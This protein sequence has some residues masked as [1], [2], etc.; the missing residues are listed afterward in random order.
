M[1]DKSKFCWILT[2][3]NGSQYLETYAK[4]IK[5]WK[6]YPAKE[7]ANAIITWTEQN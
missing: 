4:V 6:S 1:N 7:R 5:I 3:G 2:I